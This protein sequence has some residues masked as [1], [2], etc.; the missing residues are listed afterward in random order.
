MHTDTQLEIL[1]S[2]K[3]FQE[4]QALG[5]PIGGVSQRH[6][7]YHPDMLPG[8]SEEDSQRAY[9]AL[10][11]IDLS[12]AMMRIYANTSDI[13]RSQQLLYSQDPLLTQMRLALQIL[14]QMADLDWQE[15]AGRLEAYQVHQ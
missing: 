11:K 2:R 1:K 8:S 12:D 6:G 9:Q 4:L 5:H 13:A 14:V 10:A 7:T 3:L 15:F